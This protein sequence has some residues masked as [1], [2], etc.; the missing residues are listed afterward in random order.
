MKR[1]VFLHGRAQEDHDPDQLQ[2]TWEAA[3]ARG[4]A[5]ARKPPL[6]DVEI[7]F[8]YYG[9]RLKVLVDQ[10]NSPLITGILLRGDEQVQAGHEE[11]R[12]SM[13][14]EM[15]TGK[16][17]PASEI[18]KNF[19]GQVRERG[20]QNWKWV[21][22]ILRTLDGTPTGSRLLDLVTRDVSVYLT[23]IG[24]RLQI[25]EW[26]SRQ[27]PDGASV[28]VLHSLGTVVGYNILRQRRDVQAPL[29]VTLGSPLG[30]RSLQTH[31]DPPMVRPGNPAEWL[32]ARDPNDVVAL[33]PLDGAHFPV[34]PAVENKS[35][36]D[37]TTDNRHSI[38]GYLDDPVVAARIYD[39]VARM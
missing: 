24:I 15:A 29:L 10:V 3:L 16:L 1:I 13:L 19:D 21:Q 9:D 36:V 14:A 30:M 33:F 11:L 39:A 4:L 25:D 28:F 8:P 22:A 35:D 5:T 26:V 12:A 2:Q 31:L 37:N 34:S 32:N 18:E 27:V 23:Y 17:L 7:V 38:D 6:T 20:I